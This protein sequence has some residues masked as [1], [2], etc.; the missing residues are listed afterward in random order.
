MTLYFRDYNDT[1]H[2][3][4]KGIQDDLEAIEVIKKD[5]VK[6]RPNYKIYYIRT[7]TDDD[8]Q[9]WFDYGAWSEFYIS[10]ND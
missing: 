4:Q 10:K 8:N 7:W 2:E 3:V 9:H 6:R 1:W 5:M